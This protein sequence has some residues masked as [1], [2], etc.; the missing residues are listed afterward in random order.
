MLRFDDHGDVQLAE[1][2]LAIL[3]DLAIH[4]RVARRATDVSKTAKA[5]NLE[6]IGGATHAE[7]C[8]NLKKFLRRRDKNKNKNMSTAFSTLVRTRRGQGVVLELDKAEIEVSPTI[9]QHP[10]DPAPPTA[11]PPAPLIQ[12]GVGIFPD[13]VIEESG[14]CSCRFW[15]SYSGP[16]FPLRL[17]MPPW[18]V[19]LPPFGDVIVSAYPLSGCEA[20]SWGTGEAP[21]LRSGT[22]IELRALVHLTNRDSLVNSC[23]D[24]LRAVVVRQLTLGGVSFSPGLP[25]DSAPAICEPPPPPMTSFFRGWLIPWPQR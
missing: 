20:R 16:T 6:P 9:E 11:V 13:A 23:L 17:P 19:P 15:I 8:A 10:S 4:P 3:L 2:P 7:L 21:I 22:T 5:H 24:W 12:F 25:N 14:D 18:T 1:Q